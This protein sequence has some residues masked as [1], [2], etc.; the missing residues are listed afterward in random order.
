LKKSNLVRVGFIF[1]FGSGRWLVCH[2]KDSAC[3]TAWFKSM[4]HIHSHSTEVESVFSRRELQFW[5]HWWML[6]SE[7]SSCQ[8][9]EIQPVKTVASCRTLI[10]ILLLR[11]KSRKNM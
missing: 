2:T 10:I 11:A 3:T 9:C 6:T 8:L 5:Q 7:F 1:L 4:F